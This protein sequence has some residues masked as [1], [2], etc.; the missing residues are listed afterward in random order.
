MCNA[1]SKIIQILHSHH[2]FLKYTGKV[3]YCISSQLTGDFWVIDQIY[4]LR[5]L[6][7][8]DFYLTIVIVHNFTL[9]ICHYV[10]GDIIHEILCISAPVAYW[11]YS[12]FFKIRPFYIFEG[13]SIY[14]EEICSCHIFFYIFIL[15][16]TFQYISDLSCIAIVEFS[17]SDRCELIQYD[18]YRVLACFQCIDHISEFSSITLGQVCTHPKYIFILHTWEQRLECFCECN[19]IPIC[20]NVELYVELSGVY[21]IKNVLLIVSPNHPC[22]LGLSISFLQVIIVFIQ[23]VQF[24]LFIRC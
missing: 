17:P 10:F 1:F 12:F 5:S 9:I 24:I 15:H 23:I 3:G 7:G 4:E 2:S 18:G 6:G 20:S 13:T 8:F 16:R 19:I 14:A 11:R 22:S 21:P